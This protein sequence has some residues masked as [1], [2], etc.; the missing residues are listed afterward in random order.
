MKLFLFLDTANAQILQLFMQIQFN[1]RKHTILYRAFKS[2]Y[3]IAWKVSLGPC[4]TR[5]AYQADYRPYTE[6][7]GSLSPEFGTSSLIPLS[8]NPGGISKVALG[9]SYRAA[10]DHHLKSG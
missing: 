7:I 6:T 10:P 3:C 2:L 5:F 4:H 1:L 8:N 9:L